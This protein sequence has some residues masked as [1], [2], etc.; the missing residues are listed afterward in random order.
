MAV[1]NQ[2]VV[3]RLQ[4]LALL[5]GVLAFSAVA[6]A[7]I[8]DVIRPDPRGDFRLLQIRGPRGSYPQRFWLVVDRD[9]RGLWCRDGAWLRAVALRYGAVLE[10]DLRA[11]QPPPLLLRHGAPYLRVRVK[12][13]DILVD[14]RVSE[15]GKEL[16]CAVRANTNYLA[17]IQPD[18]LESIRLEPSV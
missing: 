9:P 6:P 1:M 3:W 18:S 2:A 16:S 15:R 11:S 13:L 7:Q 10:A 14:A 17:P 8:A 5:V 4:P 12:P